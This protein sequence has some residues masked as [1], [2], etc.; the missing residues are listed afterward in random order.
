MDMGVYE[1]LLVKVEQKTAFVTINRESK[2]NALNAQTLTE[3]STVF[4]LL[5]LDETVKGVI[6]TGA[7][8]K[9]FVAGADIAEFKELCPTGASLLSEK[10]QVNVMDKISN[11]PKPV[12]AAVNGFAL[13][14]GLELAMACHIRVASVNAKLGQ[15]EVSLGIIPGYGGTQRLPQLVGRGKALE[16]ILTGEMISAS[17]A[18]QWGLVNY[19]VEQD[20]LIDTCLGLF[21]KIYLKSPQA[22]SFAIAAVNEGLRDSEGGYKKEIALFGESFGT[23]EAK[24]GIQAFIEKRKPN[25]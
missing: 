14:G 7:G 9:A 18:L 21:E 24:E 19:V 2:L 22:I 12:I 8:S 25:F 17:D 1:T 15:P 13:G 11:F 16:M 10:G 4:D 5:A 23:E 6:L 3:L 20:I